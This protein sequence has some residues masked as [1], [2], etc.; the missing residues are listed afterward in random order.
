MV[1]ISEL[2]NDAAVDA[3]INEWEK[4]NKNQDATTVKNQQSAVGE[5]ELPPQMQEIAS[6]PT[7]EIMADL[8]KL[9]FFM[10]ELSVAEDGS[11]ET[12][13]EALKALAYDGEPDEIAENFKN[14]GNDCYKAK[15][16]KD[17]VEYYTKGLN[18]ECGVKH[19]EAALYLNRAA[20]NLEL[21]NFRM[22]IND[23]K[24]CLIRQPKNVKACYRAA[25]A[26]FSINH[27]DEA[28]ATLDFAYSIDDKNLAVNTLIKQVN[29]KVDQIRK[30]AEEKKK[31]E[32]ENQ[33]INDT[34]DKALK[35][36]GITTVHSSYGKDTTGEAKLHLEDPHD[37]ETQLIIPTM[38]LYPTIDEFDVISEVSELSTPYEL[39]ELVT[40]RPDEWFQDGIHDNFKPK[41]LEAYMELED[42]GLIKIGK[43]IPVNEVLMTPNPKI[44]LFDNILRIYLVPKIDT[45]E[46]LKKW[47]K[48]EALERRE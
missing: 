4:R 29:A 47:N 40:D 19:I 2:E 3:I 23:C 20:C 27:L 31:R 14:Q 28:Q 10:N 16:Y 11:N 15:K 24:E 43:K 33:K 34:L 9:P 22:T 21:K 8:N 13:V 32:E 18:V 41:K 46:W 44:P 17:A 5:P 48:R 39:M 37:V 25:K 45:A 36:R 12:E 30:K 6:K 7:E 26:Y 35:L 38:I 1:E 42:G